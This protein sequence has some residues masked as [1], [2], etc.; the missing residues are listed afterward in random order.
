MKH[1]LGRLILSIALL[2]LAAGPA[3][4]QG[5]STSSIS[6]TVVDSGGGVIP[7]A[8]VLVTGEAAGSSFT[9]TTNHEGLFSVPA[10]NPGTYKVTVTL[11]GF[12]TAVVADVRVAPN[13]PATI[14]AVL[15]V[16]TLSETITV[17]S[18][19]ELIN[20]Q[21]AT[22]TST[23][24]ADQL[25]RM[26]TATRNA[27]NA[28][29]FLPGVNTSGVNRDSTINGLPE[30]MMSI[31][32]DGV[33]NNDNFNKSTDG[34]F[35]SVTPRQDAV[36][37]VTVTTAVSGS[38]QGGSG[39]VTIN[40]T[41]RSG[42]NRLSGSVY[43][44]FRHPSLNSNYWF[45]ERNG[46]PKNEVKLNQ[47]GGRIGGPIVIPGLYDGRGT[48]FYFFHY[49][50]LRFPNSFTRTRTTFHPE[51]LDG[52]FRYAASGETRRVNVLQL[53]AQ[54]GQLATTDPTVMKLLNL[55]SSATKTTGL[56]S[57]TTNPLTNSYVWQSPGKL[58]EHQ[59]TFT[60]DYQLSTRHRLRGSAQAIWAER[61][62]DYLNSAD[63]RFPGAPNYRLFNSTRPL[64]SV[65]LRSTLTSNLVNE[66]R[67]GITALG[68]SSNFG[69]PKSNGPQSFDDLGGRAIV[70]PIA[71]DWWT[72]NNPSWR[73][74]PTISI[75][76]NVTWQ[77][78]THNFNFGGSILNS[79]AWENA[80]NQVPGLTLGFNNTFD[81]AI[82]LFNTTNFP[83]A[84]NDNLSDARAVY[85]MLTGRVSNVS[86]QAALDAN[87]N[88]YV[89][90]GPRRFEGAIRVYSLFGQ[91]SWRMTPN[92]TLTYGLRWDLQTPFKPA[93]N[94]LTAVTLESMCGM[95]GL[96]SGGTFDKCNFFSPG[97]NT[98]LVPQYIGL[99]KGNN[100]YETDWNNV[101]P[102]VGIAW[103]PNVQGGFLRTILGDPE[104]A[105]VRGGYSESFERQG[106]NVLTGVYGSNPGATLST[107]RTSANGNLVLPGE[108]W[109]ILLSQP[110]RLYPGSFPETATYPSVVRSGRQDDLNMFAPDIVIA[111]AR[112]WS[113][114]FQRAISRDMAVDI[115]Y[116]GTRGVN[117]WSELDYNTRDIEQNGFINEF[118][119]AVANLKANNA[120]G[121]NRAGSF[122][123]FGVGTSPLP[124]YLAYIN[125][126]TDATNPAAYTGSTWSAN[127]FTSDMAF[128][129]PSPGNSAADL[130]GDANRRANAIAAGLAPNLFV[131]NPAVDEAN[132]TDSGAFSDYH[133][134]Q[135]DLRRRL[136]KGLSAGVNYQYALEGGSAFLGFAYGRVMNPSTNVRHAIKT[137]WDWT[138]PVGRGHRF[139]TDAHPIVDGI[140]GG[141]SFNGVGRIQAVM[142]NFGSVNLVNMTA[143][144]LQKMYKHDIRID[145]ASGLRTVYTLPDDVI[146]NTRRAFNVSQLTADG[147]STALGAPE[148]RYIAPANSESCITVKAGDC[149]PRTLLIRAPFFTRFD[150]G[151]TKKFNLTGRSNI[152]VR[153]DMLNLFDNVNFNQ[154]ANPGTGATIFQVGSGYMDASN[155]YDPGGRLGQ[156][157]V[158]VNW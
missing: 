115:R 112:T 76:N 152:E 2:A 155:S 150:V 149:A 23:L 45:N 109:P 9:T 61:D 125:A 107:N 136:S 51:V 158:R 8:T 81:P 135:I 54:N 127:G 133:A 34:F 39:A 86:G 111:S 90:L 35:A 148:G 118:K 6:G 10:L 119:L 13:Q 153:F 151:V 46:L 55:I 3:F 19:S 12:K 143:K 17:A 146:L 93:N 44:Y 52:W 131:V 42:T 94:N 14:K 80:Q 18:S 154:A 95:S 123:Y 37:A 74:A 58:F 67:G 117:Q 66:L 1:G 60:M 82:G 101:G 21:T 32:L 97:T 15:E 75:E 85:A 22:I 49:E 65:S 56:V 92:V 130:D 110:E 63:A 33:S 121:G 40:F 104:Q 64:Y 129:N 16:G 62:P 47:T 96:G 4:A 134:L 5:S 140:L 88:E 120:A 106:L 102:S 73:S 144:D 27:L 103:K 113:I 48:A 57:A 100:G 98:G 141:W 25:N 68:G 31:T 142:V 59:P 147:Y 91:D 108:S 99:T 43:E 38:N 77:R 69:N 128:R 41:T 145:P 50:Q 72:S 53:A 132:V 116:V 11:Q 7:G 137:Q 139:L 114:S 105:T 122:A 79:R 26:P 84:S 36:E 78:G 126:R 30:S 138:L 28:V 83:G 70:I 156:L 89:F 20:T 157:M 71:T 124:T 29:T 24:N 87:T